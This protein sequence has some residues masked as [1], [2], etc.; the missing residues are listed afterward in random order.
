MTSQL[1]DPFYWKGME[2]DF[3][4]ATDIYALFDPET[5]GLHPDGFSTACYKGFIITFSVRS[6]QLYIDQLDVY[7]PDDY[8]PVINGVKATDDGEMSCYRYH[9]LNIASD[10]TGR[11]FI[12]KNMKAEYL[13]RA[14]TGPHSYNTN[15]EL[16]FE[17]GKLV[18]YR[19]TTGAYT[20]SNDNNDSFSSENMVLSGTLFQDSRCR[21]YFEHILYVDHFYKK[22][23]E[24]IPAI[25]SNDGWYWYTEMVVEMSE[26]NGL[27][28]INPYKP[29]MIRIGS[30][31]INADNMMQIVELPE[32]EYTPLCY[33]IYLCYSNNYDNLGYYTL[34][35][36]K[37]GD[38]LLRDWSSD[39][40]HGNYGSMPTITSFKKYDGPLMRMEIKRVKEIHA[41]KY[42]LSL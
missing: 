6:N 2:Y 34:E 26:G 22:T 20:A 4:G 28:L 42:G 18:Y 8:Y 12:S 27:N 1:K 32:P 14:F 29:D 38:T 5:Y 33:R 15:Y 41:Q 13:N 10:Y 23:F 40:K 25:T 36:S 9:N 24:F 39:K 30:V 17:K 7:C 37:N 16:D 31:S 3:T 11:I 21:I 35:L 19:N